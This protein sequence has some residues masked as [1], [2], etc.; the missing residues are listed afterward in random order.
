M[1][2]CSKYTDE[3]L[4][5]I[6]RAFNRSHATVIHAVDNISRQIQQKSGVR[7]QVEFLG[8]H[9]ENPSKG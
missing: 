4:E 6:G 3:T 2:F 5:T 1:Y 8:Q 9:L 7:N